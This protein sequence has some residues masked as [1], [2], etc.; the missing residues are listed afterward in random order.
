MA[1]R[2][3][4]EPTT[5]NEGRA[6]LDGHDFEWEIGIGRVDGYERVFLNGRREGIRRRDGIVTVWN[7]PGLLAPE[8]VPGNHVLEITNAEDVGTEFVIRGEDT[9]GTIRQEVFTPTQ[10]GDNVINGGEWAFIWQMGDLGPNVVS[11]DV[12]AKDQD[13]NE[14][15]RIVAGE[16]FSFSAKGRVPLSRVAI[17]PNILVRVS[18]P[19]RVRVYLYASVA[20]TAP[21]RFLELIPNEDNML[22]VPLRLSS[23]ANYEIRAEVIAGGTH[24]V[25]VYSQLVFCDYTLV[26]V[27]PDHS[28]VGIPE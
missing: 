3:T 18:D 17:V 12:I 20:G 4:Y 16:A 5:H 27:G 14:A 21:K 1:R 10:I 7:S 9:S 24:F 13:G 15:C 28:D 11:G 6:I 8:Q 2:G 22:R 25:S 26:K 23:G 19:N